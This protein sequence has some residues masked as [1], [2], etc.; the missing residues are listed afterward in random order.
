MASLNDSSLAVGGTFAAAGSA[1]ASRIARYATG[2]TGPDI[3]VQ[4]LDTSACIDQ[5]AHF[6]LG[7]TG[8]EPM[9][10]RWQWQP[11]G[12]STAWVDLVAGNNTETGGAPVINALNVGTPVLQV[13]PLAAYTNFADREFRCV[14][15][16]A[17]STVTSDSATLGVCP[18]DVNCDGQVTP[19]D[20][21]TFVNTW[22]TS[23]TAGTLA[24]DYD[25]SGTVTPADVA[26]YVG[27]WFNALT[28]GC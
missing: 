13:V 21:A 4:P 19:S 7:A 8:L 17:C 26:A 1:T 23:L 27:A 3:S 11:A 18:V 15:S 24:G 12:A 2:S 5:A 22:S 28:N 6:T 9:T 25:Q 14:A 16:N 20:I 10:Y